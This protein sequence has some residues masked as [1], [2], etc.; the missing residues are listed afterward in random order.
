MKKLDFLALVLI[1]IGGINWGL[2]GLFDFNMIDYVFGRVWID[3]V[4]YVLFGLSAIYLA[5]CFKGACI[6]T[7]SRK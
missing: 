7:R 3:R 4:F 2:Y 1:V 5:A 6:R